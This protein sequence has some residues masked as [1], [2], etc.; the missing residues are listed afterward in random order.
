V[1]PSIAAGVN[2]C[3]PTA[4]LLLLAAVIVVSGCGSSG[5]TDVTRGVA[6]CSKEVKPDA[7][8]RYEG[9]GRNKQKVAVTRRSRMKLLRDAAKKAAAE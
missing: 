7:L 4:G 6:G 2:R 3:P 8:Y 5:N 1:I 9:A